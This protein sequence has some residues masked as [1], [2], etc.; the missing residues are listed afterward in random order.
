MDPRCPVCCSGFTALARRPIPCTSDDCDFEACKTCTER[1]L[2]DTPDGVA[3]CMACRRP[4]SRQHLAVHTSRSFHAKRLREHE[5]KVMLPRE[6]AKLPRTQEMLAARD[7][8]EAEKRKVE[9]ITCNIHNAQAR[10]QEMRID[11]GR[12]QTSLEAARRAA[13]MDHH[14]DEEDNTSEWVSV[15]PME[16][17]RGFVAESTSACSLCRTVICRT[18]H[19]PVTSGHECD[20]AT[21]ATIETL[22]KETKPCPTCQIP[23]YRISG[24]DQMWC[25]ACNTPFSWKTQQILCMGSN[26]HNPHYFEWQRREDDNHRH[27]RCAPGLAVP[28]VTLGQVNDSVNAEVDGI[29]R[30]PAMAGSVAVAFTILFRSVYR[31]ISSLHDSQRKH[32]VSLAKLRA[33]YLRKEITE[34]IWL[35]GIRRAMVRREHDSDLHMLFDTLIHG[36]H[37]LLEVILFE[38]SP[39]KR[40]E[41][42]ASLCRLGEWF[43]ENA[44]E[45]ICNGDDN[46]KRPPKLIA[47][48]M[49]TNLYIQ[50]QPPPQPKSPQYHSDFFR[51]II[52]EEWMIHNSG[53]ASQDD[54]CSQS[55][56]PGV[57]GHNLAE[58]RA[59]AT[60]PDGR[61]ALFVELEL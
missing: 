35:I 39:Q 31:H 28:W 14:I 54:T 11:R 60:H 3:R 50:Q 61:G 58:N 42:V 22:H 32:D 52:E 12:C 45:V 51:G 37:D 40:W 55:S 18:C 38:S 2:L 21:V 41:A 10:L 17:C 56:R 29:K 7:V 25:V 19:I 43:N 26:F 23:I 34:E 59:F 24:C 33:R 8:V 1:F 27:Q 20:P 36:G 30:L 48:E 9:M 4:W 53:G 6:R 13:S 15:C 57:H 49:F 46:K 47:R 5:A 44:G 16:D